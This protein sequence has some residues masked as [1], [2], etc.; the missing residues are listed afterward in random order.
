MTGGLALFQYVNGVVLSA[1]WAEVSHFARFSVARP[2]TLSTKPKLHA[3]RAFGAARVTFTSTLCPAVPG[4][5]VSVNVLL[6]VSGIFMIFVPP[7]C[8]PRTTMPPGYVRDVI[9]GAAVLPFVALTCAVT[10]LPATASNAKE[11]VVVAPETP[12]GYFTFVDSV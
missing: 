10:A 3:R 6:T 9:V 8:A 1:A 4:S 7:A 12:F 2:E 11:P 5:I